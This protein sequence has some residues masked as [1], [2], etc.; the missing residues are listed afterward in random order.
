MNRG[1]RMGAEVGQV[2]AKLGKIVECW[3]CGIGIGVD[4]VGKRWG[5]E[6]YDWQGKRFDP[7]HECDVTR[8]G[9]NPDQIRAIAAVEAWL[10]KWSHTQRGGDSYQVPM[11]DSRL[12]PETDEA[13][14]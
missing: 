1:S 8:K 4:M 2:A 11:G 7:P 12:P 14:E 10:E 9:L 13:R 3:T 6:P 5:E